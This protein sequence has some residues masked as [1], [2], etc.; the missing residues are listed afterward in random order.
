M[1]EYPKV[2]VVCAWYN[3]AD[4]IRDTIDSLLAQDY[5]NFDITVVNDGSPDPRVR[6]IFDSYDDPRLRVFHQENAGFV[7]A[8]NKAIACSEG[9]YIA[10]MGAG[11]LSYPLRLAKQ[12]DFLKNNSNFAAVGC[13]YN[14]LIISNDNKSIPVLAKQ[15]IGEHNDISIIK[16]NPF[17]HGEVMI[18]RENYNDVGGY[19]LL[20][21]N[22]Q[23]KDLWLRLSMKFRLYVIDEILYE[24]RIFTKDGIVSDLKKT[25]QQI[26]YSRLAEHCHKE[27]KKGRIDSVDKYD[28]LSFV[29]LPKDS[30]TI[31]KIAKG[32]R[33]VVYFGRPEKR[34]L[35]DIKNI[36]GIRI[37]IISLLIYSIFLL[38]KKI[39]SGK[40]RNFG[41]PKNNS[42]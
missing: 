4:Y 39:K 17:S 20:F 23:D 36:Y 10:V 5:P 42:S 16:K 11:D 13:R 18:K 33:Q 19:R 35:I 9:E 3:R 7:R 40:G 34:Q 30:N 37:Y 12:S 32:I 1:T 8:M 28:K 27:R 31:L 29:S 26:A 41:T 38:E 22:S 6:E 2:S 24:R 14:N 21:I 15:K 25:I